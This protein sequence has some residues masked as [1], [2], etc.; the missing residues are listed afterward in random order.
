MK[1]FIAA[2][3]LLRRARRSSMQASAV[4][5]ALLTLARHAEDSQESSLLTSCLAAPT[6]PRSRTIV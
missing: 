6:S 4:G 3:I 1:Q 2:R 5:R